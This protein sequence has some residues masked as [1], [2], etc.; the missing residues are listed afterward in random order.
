MISASKKIIAV[1]LFS[2]AGG[3]D[4]GFSYLG[5]DIP[6]AVEYN[7]HAVY[8]YAQNFG[9]R[10]INART[11]IKEVKEKE[12]VIIWD[13]IRNVSGKFIRAL[14]KKIC[15]TENIDLI[16]GGP[17]CQS[18]SIAGTRAGD[19]DE[20]GQMVYEYLRM[21]KE[22]KPKAFLFENVK[23]IISDRFRPVFFGFMN[24]FKKAD[25]EVG[26]KLLNSWDYG[27][28]QTR[29]RII[30]VGIDM[31]LQKK[32][33]FPDP[34]PY[35]LV[36]KDVLQGLPGPQ[37][38]REEIDNGT[39]KN[40]L[41]FAGEGFCKRG[42]GD[43]T[44][45]YN[46]IIASK[47]NGILFILNGTCIRRESEKINNHY[48]C[49][50]GYSS[51]Y[52]SRNRQRQWDEPSFTIVSQAKQIP[53]YPEPAGFD[54]RQFDPGCGY[55]PPRRFTVRECMRIQAFPDWFVVY[56]NP[57]AQYMQVGNAVPVTLAYHVGVNLLRTLC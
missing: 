47:E 29:E 37:P 39:P 30:V 49:D 43:R 17:S 33:S 8:T 57:A 56:G 45:T 13:D 26:Y 20:R 21:L 15:G 54:I 35:R 18:W 32:Y 9:C 50:F 16:L 5:V 1:S 4:L 44:L 48:V 10:V 42:R 51:R 22:L 38:F 36:L 24:E 34:L 14:C 12:H 7:R 6:V 40:I 2:G 53:L 28:A 55:K 52:L 46:D 23:G 3:L 25:Y 41:N 31:A 27:V 11:D 19:K